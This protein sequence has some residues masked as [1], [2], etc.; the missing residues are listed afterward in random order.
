[1]KD[2]DKIVEEMTSLVLDVYHYALD[3]DMDISSP[4][5]VAKILKVLKPENSKEV[6]IEVLIQGL[7]AFD[8]MTKTAKAKR[9]QIVN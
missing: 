8:R 4:D 6:D 5:E 1:M 9:G 3:N 7:V 2:E